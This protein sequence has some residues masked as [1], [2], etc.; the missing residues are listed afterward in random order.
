MARLD[1]TLFICCEFA[2]AWARI[3]SGTS[4]LAFKETRGEAYNR[5]FATQHEHVFRTSELAATRIEVEN[6]G[7][8]STLLQN[9]SRAMR[10]ILDKLSGA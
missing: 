2:H 4:P 5:A 1:A 7:E 6:S 3:T 9:V 8:L 10:P